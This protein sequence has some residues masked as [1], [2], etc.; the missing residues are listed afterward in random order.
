MELVKVYVHPIITAAVR[1]KK[2]ISIK[3]IKIYY[4][5][6]IERKGYITLV[7]LLQI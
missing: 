7:V 3:M 5:Q 4:T 1:N 6:N 2:F